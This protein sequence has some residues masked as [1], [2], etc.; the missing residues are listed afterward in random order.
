[1]QLMLTYMMLIGEHDKFARHAA[2]LEDV[3]HSQTLR[4]WQTII[5]LIVDDL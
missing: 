1:M 5:E 3:K 4:D 2:S